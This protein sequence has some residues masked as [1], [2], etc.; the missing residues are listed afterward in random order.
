MQLQGHRGVATQSD[1]IRGDVDDERLP[2][3][4][5]AMGSPVRG[6]TSPQRTKHGSAAGAVRA[7]SG[8]NTV[9]G[10]LPVRSEADTAAVL[11]KLLSQP[12]V[13]SA[14][15]AGGAQAASIS[16]SRHAS[17]SRSLSSLRPATQGNLDAAAS[18]PSNDQDTHATRCT[19]RQAELLRKS[20][21]AAAAQAA[22]QGKIA[23][24]RKPKRVLH[25]SVTRDSRG[26]FCKAGEGVGP[27]EGAAPGVSEGAQGAA[28][29]GA[30]AGKA[31]GP[32]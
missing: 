7:S 9:D 6:L 30:R 28:S 10:A 20:Q 29:R 22:S 25:A 15:A 31:P 8:G 3:L 19:S 2:H 24:A 12:S 11:L 16:H 18:A 26:M 1:S 13:A 27:V 5:M 32:R 4:Q 14:A 23:A 17:H 21:A